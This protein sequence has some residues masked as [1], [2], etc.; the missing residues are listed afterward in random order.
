M[1]RRLLCGLG[2]K[3][4]PPIEIITEEA[5]TYETRRDVIAHRSGVVLTVKFNVGGYF[6]GFKT[7]TGEELNTYSDAADIAGMPVPPEVPE[8]AYLS[9]Y[10]TCSDSSSISTPEKACA[11]LY[12]ANREYASTCTEQ[13]YQ[14]S[15]WYHNGG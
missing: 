10:L 5:F 12:T 4:I 9:V 2:Q 8:G 13:Q 6:L 11:H 14:F 7:E 1:I 3:S 15:H